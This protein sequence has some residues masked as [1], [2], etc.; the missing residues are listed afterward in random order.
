MLTKTAHDFKHVDRVRK[1]ILLLAEK[2]KYPNIK[3]AEAAALLH[4]IGLPRVRKAKNHGRVGSKLAKHFLTKNKLFEPQVINEICY[5]I[6]N[7]NT[8]EKKA[9]ALLALLRDADMLD[10]LGNIGIMRAFTSKSHLPDYDPGKI[11]GET[12]DFSSADFDKRF[13]KGLGVGKTIIDQINFQISFYDNLNTKTARQK[14]KPL[15]KEMKAFILKLEK[16]VS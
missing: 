11:K 16:I 4:D 14:A 1:N 6:K 8:K 13:S 5:A 7:H 2:E 12:W 15:I 10:A 3:A 9:G